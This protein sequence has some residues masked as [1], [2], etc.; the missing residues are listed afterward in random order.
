MYNNIGT[1]TT[2]VHSPLPRD[3]HLSL[4]RQEALFI[5]RSTLKDL[6]EIGEGKEA[7]AT[8]VC[9][10]K[11]CGFRRELFSNRSGHLTF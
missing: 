9:L 2:P 11:G 5:Q 10:S 4:L 7:F 1:G 8:S 3:D 6:E